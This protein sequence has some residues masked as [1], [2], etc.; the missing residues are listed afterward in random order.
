MSTPDDH[1]ARQ[2]PA[3][4]TGEPLTRRRL[5]VA[6]GT[7]AAALTFGGVLAGCGAA[8]ERVDLT[9]RA[10]SSEVELG[11]RR[12]RTSTYDG[13]LP[14]REL[15]LKQGEPVRI[16]LVNDLEQ[17]TSIHWHGIRLQNAA[18][19]VPGFTQKPVG[20][21]EE[22]VYAFTPPDAG[23]FFFHPHVGVQLDRGL[24]APLIVE[25]RREPLSYDREAVL[26]FDDWLDGLA[27]TPERRL[28][29]LRANG[30]DMGAMHSG[31]DTA[32]NGMG[33]TDNAGRG[34]SRH[35][36][37][38]GRTPG[39]DS[40]ARLAN[41]L[42]AGRLDP[43]DVRDYPLYLANGRPPD[44]P[45]RITVRKGDRLRLRL[46]NPS[47]DTIF[48]VFVERH[49]LEVVHA[50][51]L[52]VRPVRTDAVILGMGERYDAMLQ[53][54][55]EGVARIVAV[56]LGKRGRAIALLR[57]TD[58]TA[59]APAPDAPVRMPRRVLSYDDLR[60]AGAP[61]RSGEEP[62]LVRLDLAM[63]DAGYVWTIGGQ[64][65]PKADP[66]RVRRGERIRFVMRNRTM[67]PHPMHLH[68]HSFSVGGD[69][70]PLK[71]TALALPMREL[72]LDWTADNPGSWAYHCHNVYHQEAGMMRRVEVA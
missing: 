69:G 58:S 33:A 32:M 2:P 41:E 13:Q 61:A 38:D 19:G 9:V 4:L 54:S 47:A 11:R 53:V 21:G 31:S 66:I 8:R 15:R 59:R 57:N 3:N 56:A 67:M 34:R 7:G 50:D 29:Q 1:G 35:L 49:E 44:D 45:A 62:R 22:F 27:G 65:F 68:G 70:G 63:R 12:A 26:M 16:R 30:M 39:P 24:Y 37:V 25:P 40:L 43:G 18:D 60:A 28:A 51:G 48:C 46:I 6:G 71:D 23:T 36:S 20:A 72:V 52:A 55:G 17:P 42:E 14:G 5:L 10:M 64:A